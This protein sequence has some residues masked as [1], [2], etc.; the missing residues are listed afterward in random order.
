MARHKFIT[1]FNTF[2]VEL[3][4]IQNF[5]DG[6]PMKRSITFN[7]IEELIIHIENKLNTLT[8]KK[9]REGMIF[10]LNYHF[11]SRPVLSSK[12]N[13]SCTVLEIIK[14]SQGWRLF[15]PRREILSACQCVFVNPQSYLTC[16]SD[17]L[18]NESF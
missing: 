9:D 15:N 8:Y 3:D 13:S 16:F 17:F 4:R 14:L 11:E 12:M 1:N 2:Q 10:K 5:K 6:S 7:Q 18:S